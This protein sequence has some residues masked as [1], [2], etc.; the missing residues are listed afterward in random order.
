MSGK[1]K[2]EDVPETPGRIPTDMQEQLLVEKA[3]QSQNKL[4]G[5]GQ[6]NAKDAEDIRSSL[7]DDPDLE[8]FKDQAK[9]AAN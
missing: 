3:E 6:V 2:E 8:N 4:L 1:R 7:N 5:S 9:D